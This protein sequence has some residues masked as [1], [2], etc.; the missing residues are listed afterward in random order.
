[1]NETR[2]RR[3]C[4]RT[5]TRP[6]WAT[7]RRRRMGAFLPRQRWVQEQRTRVPRT[8][9]CPARDRPVLLRTGP[10]QPRIETEGAARQVQRRPEPDT[11]HEALEL[12]GAFLPSALRRNFC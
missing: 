3:G 9:A 4:S 10:V 5:A 12:R 8:E 11:A 2:L 6:V 1:M 7:S